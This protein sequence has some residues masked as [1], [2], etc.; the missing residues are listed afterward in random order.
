MVNSSGMIMTYPS[1]IG[2]D[3]LSLLEVCLVFIG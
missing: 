2:I 3:T 1:D